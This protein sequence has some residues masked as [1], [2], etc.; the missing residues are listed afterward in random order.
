MTAV[1]F[2]IIIACILLNL[3]G[4]STHN[5]VFERKGLA[6]RL[7]YFFIPGAAVL[8]SVYDRIRLF[9]V[10]W[11]DDEE[12]EIFS[13]LYIGEDTKDKR[14]NV[15]LENI[16]ISI[17]V[18]FFSA[19]VGLLM[20]K[21]GLYDV[22]KIE[23]L[24]RPDNGSSNADMMIQYDGEE[25]PISI[26]VNQVYPTEDEM[27]ETVK[28]VSRSLEKIILG[29]NEST[30]Y[31]VGNLNLVNQAD[32][33]LV[34]I[35]WNSSDGYIV[36]TTGTVHNEE[37]Y[38]IV[39]VTV[40]ATIKYF[41]YEEKCDFNLKVYPVNESSKNIAYIKNY[42]DELMEKSKYDKRVELPDKV[43]NEEIEFY[44]VN[45]SNEWAIPIIGL[46]ISV[47]MI[48]LGIEKRKNKMEERNR[49]LIIDYPEVISK[50]TLLLEAGNTVRGSFERTALDYEKRK[51]TSKKLRYVYE[52]MLRTRNE[53]KIGRAESECYEE[54]GKRCGNMYYIRFASLLSQ[55]VKL[56]G[57]NLIPQLR[58]EVTEVLKERQSAIRKRGEETSVKL[59]IPMAGMFIIIILIIMIPAFMTMQM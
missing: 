19:C 22:N 40:T 49:E 9:F 56:G 47:L 37:L 38:D 6:E 23:Y 15:R 32:N 58:K 30:D 31:I 36:G 42:I 44:T 4:I 7:K 59:L 48:F 5:Y 10:P 11:K 26:E 16:N 28:E 34:T 57:E 51:K 33:P 35:S 52:E 46:I 45:D 41:E 17:V 55:S 21:S 27:I 12:K 1:S 14:R 54:M 8:L 3:V 2:A 39:N 13:K 24:L 25:I 29:E 20:S 53:I 43:D 18:L 50:F